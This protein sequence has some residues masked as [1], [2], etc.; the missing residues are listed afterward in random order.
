MRPAGGSMYMPGVGHPVTVDRRNTNGATA[1]VMSTS[2]AWVASWKKR[3]ARQFVHKMTA[4]TGNEGTG[5]EVVRTRDAQ[6]RPGC[7]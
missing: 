2:S 6:R 3:E 5:L 4:T 1:P 7:V